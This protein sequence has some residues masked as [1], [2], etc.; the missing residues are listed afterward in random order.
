MSGQTAGVQSPETHAVGATARVYFSVCAC[1]YMRVCVVFPVW[2]EASVG[3]VTCD[4]GD[5][6]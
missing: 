4:G 5:V 3:Q 6:G 2:I 1:V